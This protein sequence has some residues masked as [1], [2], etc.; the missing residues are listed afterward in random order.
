MEQEID[1]FHKGANDC[2]MSR[3][4]VDV[5][6]EVQRLQ[7]E[8]RQLKICAFGMIAL[9]V[10]VI[11]SSALHRFYL[12][13]ILLLA[14]ILFQFI[15]FRKKQKAYQRHIAEKNL[16]ISFCPLMHAESLVL[17]GWKRFGR[18]Q[19]LEAELFP[20]YDHGNAVNAYA[21]AAGGDGTTRI[22]SCDVSI[23]EP[24]GNGSRRATINCGNWTR[25]TFAEPHGLNCRILE[26]GVLL[27]RLERSF[28]TEEQY[29][30]IEPETLG[31]EDDFSVYRKH[32]TEALPD[33]R[34]IEQLKKLAKYTPGKLAVSLHGNVM[35]VYIRDRFIG[36]SYTTQTAI[37]EE[38]LKYDPFP[39]IEKIIALGKT[40]NRN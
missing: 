31:L 5:K 11:V 16:W 4:K 15:Y 27:D 20:T 29:A 18:E 40:L 39:E 32:G 34:L 38:M 23:A 3:E 6:E 35:D 2:G 17:S 9:I 21:G 7:A 30:R 36:V 26:K 10:A 19:L 33:K 25:M 14:A 22:E 12:T 24:Y 1:I 13:G 8:Y 37:S 28:Y